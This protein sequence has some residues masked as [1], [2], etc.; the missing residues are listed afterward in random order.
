MPESLPA[1]DSSNISFLGCGF[2]H[3]FL[4]ILVEE[5][6][7]ANGVEGPAIIRQDSEQS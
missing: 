2:I 4:S 5:F 6:P 1:F 7:W 3:W